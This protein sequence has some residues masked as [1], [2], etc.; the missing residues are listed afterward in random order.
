MK[1]HDILMFLLIFNL[2]LWLL[3]GYGLNIYRIGTNYTTGIKEG[4]DVLEQNQG[5]DIGLAFLLE[6]SGIAF[7]TLIFG[8][9]AASVAGYLLRTVPTPQSGIY[10]AFAGLFWTSYI[11]TLQVFY[12]M[13]R[14]IPAIFITVFLIFTA[15]TVFTF[16]FGFSQI[17]TGSWRYMK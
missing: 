11:K 10:Y 15:I 8:V 13:A 16:I 1:A 4:T 7:L 14:G 6:V 3:G 12:G 2:T 5:P 17:V 9:A